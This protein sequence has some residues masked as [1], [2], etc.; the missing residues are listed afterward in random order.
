MSHLIKF[1]LL[2]TLFLTPLFSSVGDLGYEQ[3]K[4]LVFLFLIS[5]TGILWLLG[6]PSF[7][8]SQIQK[9]ALI[10]IF[11]LFITSL[12]GVKPQVSLLGES[13]YFQGFILYFELFLFS[14]IVSRLDI[15]PQSWFRFLMLSAVLVSAV[16]IKDAINLYFL[17]LAVPTYAGRVVSTFGQPN[18]Y[19]GFV[20]LTL[21][22]FYYSITWGKRQW[23]Y[24]LGF[25]V[26]IL[27]I[28][29]SYSKTAI[30]MT[31]G[32]II[33]WLAKSLGRVWKFLIP[34]A[35]LIVISAAIFAIKYQEGF[36]WEQLGKPNPYYSIINYSPEKRAYIWPYILDLIGKS[37][38]LGYGLENLRGI[39]GTNIRIEEAK[40]AYAA[41][42]KNLIVDRSHNYLLDLLFFSGILGLGAWIVL[43]LAIFMKLKSKSD[44]RHKMVLLT[45]FLIYLIWIQFQNQ[46]VVH[47]I[48]FWW[49]VGV[50]D[51]S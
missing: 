14:I 38:I 9:A 50:V 28:V 16:A 11:I 2:A 49:L 43:V 37:P 5:L 7:K 41:D 33:F 3:S 17:N 26:C 23:I 8:L 35:A 13:P 46:S 40:V 21:P 4:V 45:S 47:L 6:K 19:G 27:A 36:L 39:F 20:L 12:T 44:G 22:L 10:F 29:L 18:F 42:L 1:L 48:Y 24:A 31:G 34:L 51:R 25:F 30:F 15:A 32:L